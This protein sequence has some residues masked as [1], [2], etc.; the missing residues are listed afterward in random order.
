MLASLGAELLKL[1]KRRSMWVLAVIWLVLTILLDYALA[2]ALLSNAP[3]PTFPAGTPKAQKEQLQKQQ[4]AFQEQQL[5]LLYPERLVSNVTPGLPNLGDPIA[6]IL[7]ALA[8]GSEYGWTTFKIVLTQRP[9]RSAV[10]FGKLLALGILLALLV[11]LTFAAGAA[12]SY[13]VA[14]L[15]GAPAG[16]P[17]AGELLGALGA[18]WLILAAWAAFG[19][20]LATLLRSTALSIGIGLVYSLVLETIIVNLPIQ[21][22]L[23]ADAREYLP[24]QNSTFL[25]NSFSG[26]GGFDPAQPPVDALQATLVLLAYTAASVA[27][28]AFVFSRRDVN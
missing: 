24:G 3:P 5:E 13:V 28:A 23:F 25:A 9:G 12:S 10:F 21:D 27:L 14:W 1:R 2:Y 17:A 26:Q 6:L 18:G 20:L 4:E 15:E 7:G 8:V 16:L 19:A 11:V 22:K